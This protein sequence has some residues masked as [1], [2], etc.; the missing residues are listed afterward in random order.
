MHNCTYCFFEKPSSNDHKFCYTCIGNGKCLRC[1]GD[2][3]IADCRWKV[4]KF[5]IGVC[6]SCGFPQK[7]LDNHSDF[8]LCHLRDTILPICWYVFRT[9]RWRSNLQKKWNFD[10][11]LTASAEDAVSFSDWISQVDSPRILRAVNVAMWAW[12]LRKME[13]VARPSFPIG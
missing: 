9:E 13:R 3:G 11:P 5:A 2:H 1:L 10:K 6:W 8:R 7:L 12:N 4:R